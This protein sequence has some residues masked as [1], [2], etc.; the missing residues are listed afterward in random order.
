MTIRVRT[1]LM[2]IAVLAM[3]SL[4]S[5]G[6]YTCGANFGV[7]TCTGGPPSLS[8]GNGSSAAAFVFVANGSA[9]GSVVGYTLNTSVAPPTL[10][11]TPNYT[12]PA[13]PNN[14]AGL[15]LTV[16]QKKFLYAAFGSTQ[17]VFGWTISSSGQLA[18]VS[19][20][21]FPATGLAIIATGDF[22]TQRVITNP[23]GTLLFVGD[24]F[25]NQVFVYQ[26]GSAGGLTAVANSPFIVPFAPGNMTT[27]GLGK[28]LYFTDS[29][30]STH[31]GTQIAAY[32]IGASGA[33]SAVPG[34][35]FITSPTGPS[36]AMWQVQGEPT[37]KYLI[38]TSGN[39]AAPQFS[40]G[41]SGVDDKHLYVFAINQSTGA[42]APA[43]GSPFATT[44]SPFNIA[45]QQNS[46]GDLV[47]SFSYADVGNSFN[48]VESYVLNSSGGLTVANG[49][50]YGNANVGSA[51]QFDQSGG[52]LFIYGGILNVNTV[53]YT[54][55]SFDVTGGSL[56]TST[57]IGTYGGHWLVTDA[58]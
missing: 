8:G 35:P 51:G 3:M 39:S 43:T 46:G 32:S 24:E 41:D 15:G 23:A 2:L 21:P 19:G 34:S 31:T 48:A 22:D 4:A 25:S 11:F 45:V 55:T 49:S 54:L 1:G 29:N 58:P 40:Q 16:A 27:D 20:S 10:T 14:D 5:C 28:Y 52:L 53:V 7:S 9:T 38:G 44:Y 37:G 42:I 12:A 13:T 36:Y 50:P 30:D 6:H 56:T 47:D 18:A 17:Q 33:L 57:Q 26:I